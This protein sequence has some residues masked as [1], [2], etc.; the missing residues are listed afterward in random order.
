MGNSMVFER[1]NKRFPFQVW[2]GSIMLYSIW[3]IILSLF[4]TNSTMLSSD[5]LFGI[6][7]MFFASAYLSIPTFLLY[8]LVFF[9]FTS[10]LNSIVLIKVVQSS[11]AILGLL[12]T[13]QLLP[14]N[15]LISPSKNVIICIVGCVVSVCTTSLYFKIR[16]KKPKLPTTAAL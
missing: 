14:E 6:L 3:T 15:S 4:S 9:S 8:L 13:F 10:R 1:I 12:L 16:T 2:I 7:L 11:I 5:F